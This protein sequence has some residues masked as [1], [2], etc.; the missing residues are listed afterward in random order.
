MD[1]FVDFV[2]W[3]SFPQ[4]WINSLLFYRT[5]GLRKT[6][7]IFISGVTETERAVVDFWLVHVVIT[8]QTRGLTGCGI[9]E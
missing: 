3:G 9:M 4:M 1:F 5:W 6:E 2:V 8:E 7:Q